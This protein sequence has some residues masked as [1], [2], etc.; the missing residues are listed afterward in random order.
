MKTIVS[1]FLMVLLTMSAYGESSI[2]SKARNLLRKVTGSDQEVS[3][4]DLPR[5]PKISKDSTSTKT[6]ESYRDPNANRFSVKDKQRYDYFY[7]EE[8]YQATRHTKAN[9]NEISQWMNVIGQGGSREGVYR[10]VVLGRDYRAM[11][12]YTGVR[13]SKKSIEFVEHFLSQYLKKKIKNKNLVSANMYSVKRLITEMSLEVMDG[14]LMEG[15]QNDLFAW[16]GVLSADLATKYPNIW[17]SK[18]RKNS[19]ALSQMKWAKA[20]PVQFIK[21]EVIIKIHKTINTLIRR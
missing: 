19:D 16:Y 14:F 20:V 3:R 12:S 6:S 18:Q 2:F 10:A 13:L 15:R 9:A 5:I 7:I 17:K 21:S 4:V 11:E 1:V 8:L